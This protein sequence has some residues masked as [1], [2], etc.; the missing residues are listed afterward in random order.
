[1][2]CSFWSIIL[3]LCQTQLFVG[4]IHDDIDDPS[5][6]IQWAQYKV[7]YNQRYDDVATDSFRYLSL[8][9]TIFFFLYIGLISKTI[10]SGKK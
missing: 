5:V 7:K 1:M 4:A 9:L 10:N 3:F 8:Q 2:K 6:A